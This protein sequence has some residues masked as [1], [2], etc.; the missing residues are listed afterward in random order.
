M[1][2]NYIQP[3]IITSIRYEI[4]KPLCGSLDKATWGGTT[5]NFANPDWLNEGHT[6]EGPYVGIEGDAGTIDSQTKGR[7]AG[8]G[9][10]W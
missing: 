6:N 3:E 2:K 7:G 1:K 8:W 10:I 4:E 9:N 5:G